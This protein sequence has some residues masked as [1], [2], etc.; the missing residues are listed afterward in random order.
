MSTTHATV[1]AVQR[2]I[3]P[4]VDL[5]LDLYGQ[6]QHDGRGCVVVYMNKHSIRKME[7]DFGRRPVS[8]LAEWLDAYKVKTTGGSTI[9]IGHR[10]QRVRRR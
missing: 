6:E 8:R 5:L 10:T 7:R 2:G 3:P 1:R 9:T 4:M